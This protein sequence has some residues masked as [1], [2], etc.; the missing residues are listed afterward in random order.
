[1]Y[2]VWTA[3][4]DYRNGQGG[5]I[6]KKLNVKYLIMFATALLLVVVLIL[7]IIGVKRSEGKNAT[8]DTQQNVTFNQEK[9]EKI[10]GERITKAEALRL[11]SFFF[12]T[13]TERK[14]LEERAV[15]SDA[16]GMWYEEYANAAVHAGLLMET[17]GTLNA[18]E[19]LNCGEF[20][21]MLERVCECCGIRIEY[22]G[23]GWPKRLKT[24]RNKDEVLLAE[25]MQL[26]YLCMEQAV[27]N[28]TEGEIFP[29]ERTSFLVA[30][31]KEDDAGWCFT[32]ETGKRYRCGRFQDYTDLFS[33][34]ETG[35]NE[36]GNTEMMFR[37]YPKAEDYHLMVPE[38][39]YCGNEIV[40]ISGFDERAVTIPNALIVYGTGDTLDTYIDGKGIKLSCE[41]PLQEQLE[42]QIADITIQNRQVT[43]L[44][45]KPDTIRGKV[46]MTGK[47]QIEIEGY[48]VLPLQKQY[49]IYKLYGEYAMEPTNSI[50]VGYSNVT[51]VM[52]GDTICAALITEAIKAENIRVLISVDRTANYQHSQVVLSSE[53]SFTSTVG[54]L[55]KE[56]LPG[57][58]LVFDYEE[59]KQSGERI[60]IKPFSESGRIRVKSITR[61]Y[62][63]PQYRGTLE[64]VAAEEGLLLVNELPLEEY[65]YSVVPSEM[66]VSHGEEALKVQA[67]CA[68]SYA[69]QQLMANRYARYGAHVDDTVNCQVYNN[70]AETN[71][72]IFAV[73]DTYGKVM[74]YG[75][76]VVTAFY[77]STSSG[78]TS[79]IEEVWQD[80]APVEYFT[81]EIQLT[82][83]SRYTLLAEAIRSGVLESTGD[84]EADIRQLLQMVD[85]SE[86]E[87]F[88]DFIREELIGVVHDGKE[89]QKKVRTYDSDFSWYRWRVNLD[90]VKLSEQLDCLLAGRIAATPK[91]ILTLVSADGTFKTPSGAEITGQYASVPITTVGQIQSIEPVSRAKSGM[92]VE[93]LIRGSANTI[94][95]RN[96]T[97]I[98]TLLAP[99]KTTV[100]LANDVTVDGFSLVPSAFFYVE[101]GSSDGRTVF[102]LYGGGYGHGVGMS[103]N[104]VKSLADAGYTY[105]GI[106]K[107]YYKGISLGFIY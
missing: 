10:T 37:A 35:T 104:G 72:S 29:I 76:S 36:Q 103:Q 83:D 61:S 52:E 21:E 42:K 12:Y 66:P 75:D 9:E 17:S 101:P 62:G 39:L 8:S 81:G 85:L 56:H 23:G 1:M 88:R 31:V 47:E 71:S 7:Y 22:F 100:Y 82:A 70:V 77:F 25:F 80:Y 4:I 54:T 48:G 40:L 16:K 86:E 84:T 30:T 96:Q 11:F 20:R 33:G 13:D 34:A 15:F 68:R 49:R 2:K 99:E 51:F 92:V 45:M 74:Q 73:K 79:S 53:D 38:L 32:D 26:Y 58:E 98:R 3:I 102:V 87:L 78:Y 18:E 28:S 89:F 97:N 55:V 57:E 50:L 93:L 65:L 69:Y 44:V 63:I 95:V 5:S 24:A 27:Q 64:V 41:F 94:L 60:V 14:A 46:L 6:M 90:A 43:G 107:H 106:L 105:E 67:V 19:A 59:L 91:D